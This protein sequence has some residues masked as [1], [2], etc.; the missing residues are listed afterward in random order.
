M[1]MSGTKRLRRKLGANFTVRKVRRVHV[2]VKQA[3]RQMSST[4][5]LLS[6]F[7]EIS[8]LSARQRQDDSGIR[9]RGSRA[10]KVRVGFCAG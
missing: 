6:G 1:I 5:G 3:A 8:E 4:C 2:N 7:L 9:I 10:V